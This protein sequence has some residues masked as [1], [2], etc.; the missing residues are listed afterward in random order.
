M[1]KENITIYDI[2]KEANVSPATVSRVLTGNAKVRPQTMRKIV[3]VIEK[4]NFRPNSLA[5]SLLHKQSKTIG[6]ILPDIN[7]PFFSTL[8]QKSEAHALELGYTSFL[9]NTMNSSENESKYLQSLVE[10]QVDGIIYL[11]GRINDTDTEQKYADEMKKVMERIPVVF[12]NGQ[13]TGV[14]A[15]I[16]RTDEESGIEKLVELLVNLNHKKIGFLGGIEGIS[17]TDVKTNTFV[18]MMNNKG[19]DVNKDWVFGNG[20][21]IESGEEVAAQLLYLKERPTAVICVN[22][23]VAIGVIKVLTKFGLKVPDDVSVVGFDDIYLAEHFPPGIT[24]VS[25]NYDLLG[26]TAINVLADLINERDA[27]RETVVPTSLI[28][29]DSCKLLSE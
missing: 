20:F 14:D 1:K 16:V 25:Q 23:F 11:G 17:S 10:K 21:S 27:E 24:T 29:R 18:K 8:V 26:E 22:D 12:V 13:M 5:R 9:C 7:H 15:H 19:L 2:A 28:L 6:F 3:D 4:Y